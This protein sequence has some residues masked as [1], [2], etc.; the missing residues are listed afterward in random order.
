MR[1]YLFRGK[2]PDGRWVYGSLIHVGDFCCILNPDDENDMD[3]PYL[4]GDLG[5]IDGKATPVIPETV[6]EYT[7]VCDKTGEKIFE[8][9]I[10]TLTEYVKRT[11][12]IEDGEVKFNHGAF[13]VNG[14]N[15]MR[16]SLFCIAD[17]YYVL[18]GEVVGNRWDNPELLKGE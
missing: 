1:D 11:F 9:D 13:F 17:I 2:T 6:G 10:V 4:D 3:Y 5:T 14:A 15:G 7:G 18:R 8:G 16:D 12:N